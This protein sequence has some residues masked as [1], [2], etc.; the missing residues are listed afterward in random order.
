MGDAIAFV[1]SDKAAY[2]T[3]TVV[4]MSGGLDLFVF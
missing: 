1:A 2:M 4:N 3:G